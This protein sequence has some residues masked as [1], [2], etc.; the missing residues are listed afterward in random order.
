MQLVINTHGSYLRK[1]G[2][3]FLIKNEDVVCLLSLHG[4]NLLKKFSRCGENYCLS[5]VF[6]AWFYVKVSEN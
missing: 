5:M 6:T 1:N 3:C 2:D 4:A